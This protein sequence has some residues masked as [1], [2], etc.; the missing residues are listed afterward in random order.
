MRVSFARPA[1]ASPLSSGPPI[2]RQPPRDLARGQRCSGVQ[3]SE[4]LADAVPTREMRLTTVLLL[5]FDKK[6]DNHAPCG[7]GFSRPTATSIRHVERP[8]S[9]SC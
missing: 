2:R 1:L 7:T 6:E 4:P 8:R 3:P 5:D 9:S